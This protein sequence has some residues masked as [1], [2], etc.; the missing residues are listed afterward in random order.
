MRTPTLLDRLKAL[1]AGLL[2][3]VMAGA[4]ITAGAADLG[5]AF[6]G[7][8]SGTTVKM[9][10]PGNFQSQARGT[11]I[12]GGA[13]VRFPQ[14]S[15]QLFSITP[16]NMS[17]GCNGIDF[18]FGGFS[19]I[20]GE[21]FAQLVRN[22]GQAAVGHVIMLA[23]KQL[24]PQ[25]Q[26]V[27]EAMQ[28]AAQMAQKSSMDS[29]QTGMAL[30]QMIGDKL[31]PDAGSTSQTSGQLC[32][33]K[34][35]EEGDSDSSLSAMSV[36]D[37]ICGTID[38]AMTWWDD[39]M[40]NSP[41][42]AEE[43]AGVVGNGTWQAL[44]KLGFK[45]QNNYALA[46]IMMTMT[47]YA[48]LTKAENQD[49]AEASTMPPAMAP[50]IMI[51]LLMC[52]TQ[53]TSGSAVVG[54]AAGDEYC[55]Q[56]VDASTV[57]IFECDDFERCEH[58]REVA[59]SSWK[60]KND[61]GATRGFL[62]LVHKTL[63][64]AAKKV[65]ANQALEA[66][67][68]A[69]IQSAPL[70][71]YKAINVAAVYPTVA[72]QLIEN[73]AMMLGYLYADA[74]IRQTIEDIRKNAGPSKVPADLIKALMDAQTEMFEK[75]DIKMQFID[76]MLVRQQVFMAEI[77]KVERVMQDTIWSRGMMGNQL[78]TQNVMSSVSGSKP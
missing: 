66:P 9:T 49:K 76:N 23:L 17:S 1:A 64:D 26:A 48:I 78:F 44:M 68:I 45:N 8:L 16:P 24:C 13:R 7:L 65:A 43:Y 21:Q 54:F 67:E 59:L 41:A 11:Y 30:G 14:T 57:K 33:T 6:N 27:I 5:G 37:G 15:V 56:T 29:C 39:L 42:K 71:L 52:G 63:T 47:G 4:P 18:F 70:P 77:K 22:I 40:Q 12:L 50:S 61:I 55:K 32:G 2:L 36:L 3:G 46:E 38:K 53:I 75:M 34:S 69:F 72:M 31:F 25:C 60:R 58:P 62:Y 51:D 10:E 35:S 20:S 73:N 28:K 19:Y 74:Y